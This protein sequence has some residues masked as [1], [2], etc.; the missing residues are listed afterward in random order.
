MSTDC[1][2]SGFNWDGKPTGKETTL[3]GNKAYVT[4]SNKDAAILFVHDVF[5]WTF[6]NLRLL[7]DHYAKEANA[8]VYLPDFFGGEVVAVE[9]LDDPERREAFDFPSFASRN[10]KEKRYPE[11]LACAKTLKS[12]YKKVGAI[13]FCY[14]GWAVFQLGADANLL[15]CISTAHPSLLE[16]KEIDGLRVP[17]QILAPENDF[18]LTPE[19]KEYCNK[20][21]PGNAVPYEYVFFP[22][23]E[24]GFAGRGDPKDV[25]QKEGLERAKRAAVN[26]FKEWLH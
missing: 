20:A 14:G 18:Q 2:K 3:A 21:I 15:S 13:G 8:T 11:L 12:Q 17:T 22:G 25:K 26:W 19:L 1:C 23:L 4:G 9:I 24:H 6:N 10:S 5:G 7:A 16:K